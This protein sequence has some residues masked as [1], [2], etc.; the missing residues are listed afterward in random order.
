[1]LNSE[2][3][4]GCHACWRM[5]WMG[6]LLLCYYHYVVWG[7]GAFS[8]LTMLCARSLLLC[9][10]DTLCFCA[11]LRVERHPRYDFPKARTFDGP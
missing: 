6:W 1:M 11:R 5:F 7:G 10:V 9:V 2:R 3:D 4:E 8:D